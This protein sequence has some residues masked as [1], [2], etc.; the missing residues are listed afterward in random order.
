ML[1]QSLHEQLEIAFNFFV[2]STNP[3]EKTIVDTLK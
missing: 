1:E 3:M 2:N